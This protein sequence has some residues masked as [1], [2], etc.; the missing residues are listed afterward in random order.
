MSL[1]SIVCLFA[2]Y[3]LCLPVLPSRCFAVSLLLLF[4]VEL[5]L[6]L[7]LTLLLL[8]LPPPPRLLYVLS[9][10]PRTSGHGRLSAAMTQLEWPRPAGKAA[11]M[12]WRPATESSR[13]RLA[14]VAAWPPALREAEEEGVKEGGK[15]RLRRR[16]VW[17]RQEKEGPVGRR[18]TVAV[19]QL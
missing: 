10:C 5:T 14:G 13:P 9:Q 1:R 16:L 17:G 6:T 12:R 15:L 4:G 8:L 19:R 18:F 7:T 2:L 11:L 3:I